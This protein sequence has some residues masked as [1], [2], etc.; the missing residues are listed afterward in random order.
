MEHLAA[1]LQLNGSDSRSLQKRRLAAA[2]DLVDEEERPTSARRLLPNL[3]PLACRLPPCPP[4]NDEPYPVDALS[5]SP[6]MHGSLFLRYAAAAPSRPS[7]A[8]TELSKALLPPL[9]CAPPPPPLAFLRPDLASSD[10]Q[11]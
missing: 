11:G 9:P 5:F 4:A 10:R 3:D 6:P 1:G 7:K 2:R 8:V